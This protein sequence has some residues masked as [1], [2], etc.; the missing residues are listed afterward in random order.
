MSITLAADVT[1]ARMHNAGAVVEAVSWHIR[2]EL[3]VVTAAANANAASVNG[4]GSMLGR[5]ASGS[6]RRTAMRAR[7]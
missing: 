2:H 3:R 6:C 7:G 1:T 5:Q 4:S